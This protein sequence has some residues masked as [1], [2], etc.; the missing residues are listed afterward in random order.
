M[1]GRGT[2]LAL[3]WRGGRTSL[4][5]RRAPEGYVA[6]SGRR[7]LPA[8]AGDAAPRFDEDR[9]CRARLG[10]WC[11]SCG[12]WWAGPGAQSRWVTEPAIADGSR[13]APN[14]A[15]FPA[16]TTGRTVGVACF[17]SPE[18]FDELL[19][20]EPSAGWPPAPKLRVVRR[21]WSSAWRCALRPQSPRGGGAL[22]GGREGPQRRCPHRPGRLPEG[23]G[24][25]H[26]RL[27]HHGRHCLGPDLG[28]GRHVLGAGAH[29]GQHRCSSCSSVCPGSTR[30]G[31]TS[32]PG[33]HE[34]LS[35]TVWHALRLPGRV[36]TSAPTTP[37]PCATGTAAR[38]RGA[39]G[40]VRRGARGLTSS[41]STTATSTAP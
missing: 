35:G 20:G 29:N 21:T 1:A 13:P 33:E 38:G 12:S 23:A 39:R 10:P 8:G 22:P 34:L 11:S 31:T 26:C 30:P 37:A 25:S 28:S 24:R 27:R 32:G 6:G 5:F 3:S 9:R 41:R 7:C 4:H 15:N 17:L 16:C 19:A 2:A 18:W 40:P 36:G 14:F